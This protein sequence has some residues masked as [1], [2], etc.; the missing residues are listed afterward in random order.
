MN[1][2]EVIKEN[3]KRN[4]ELDSYYNPITGE[5]SLIPKIKIYISNGSYISMP[6]HVQHFDYFK[7][8]V[9]KDEHFH[10]YHVI[11]E[12]CI[13][14]DDVISDLVR[15][16]LKEDFEF[17]AAICLTIKHKELNI[18]T[19][20]IFNYAQRILHAA[21]EKQRMS[22]LPERI[23]TCKARQWGS[24]TY[25]ILRTFWLQWRTK[26][27]NACIVSTV[28]NQARGVRAKYRKS[29]NRFPKQLG[30]IKLG[31]FEGSDKNIY[32]NAFES[33]ISIGSME[34]PESLRSEDNQIAL[35]TEV[36]S[37]KE[38]P[39]R[40][41]MDLVQNIKASVLYKP[42][43]MIVEES[44]AKGTGNYW[45]NSWLA[46]KNNSKDRY[47]GVFIAWFQ[48]EM[49]RLPIK[50]EEYSGFINSLSDDEKIMWAKGA[51]LEGLKW[52]R[53]HLEFEMLGNI[54]AMRSEYPSD[55]LEAFQSTGHKR[56][57][58]THIEEMSA[59]CKPPLAKGQVFGEGLKGKSALKDLV[60][61]PTA[62]GDLWLWAYPDKKLL[63]KNRYVVSVDI[64]GTH[65]KSDYSVMRIFD[66]LPMMYGGGPDCIGTYRGHIDQ[67]TFAWYC[68]MVSTYFNNALLII[69]FNSL[70]KEKETEGEHFLTILDE[71]KDY[72]NNI[73]ARYI[74]EDVRDKI[75]TKYGFHTNSATKTMIIDLYHALLRDIGYIEYDQ[76]AMNECSMFEVKENGTLGAVKGHHD[77][78]VIATSIGLWACTSY[79]PPPKEY[80]KVNKNIGTKMVSESIM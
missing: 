11:Y 29:A 74:P 9:R 1:V 23:K 40:T 27:I 67:D 26:G 32:N 66:R 16:R 25:E 19:A 4:E 14:E 51:T 45:H 71:I 36:G 2:R 52:Y 69:E 50:S 49:Y 78:I 6:E 53:N 79:L 72:Y 31:R 15:I 44:T 58:P 39:S 30:E 38:T 24:T 59:L 61:T 12:R 21:H 13:K 7:K 54:W 5:G 42:D 55:D 43:T 28:E 62:N 3:R 80:T 60:F 37:W 22:G 56:F 46:T 34:K 73:Y 57:N 33:I 18:D 77:D 47:I 70:D 63:I 75:P 64:G 35:C 48:I 41:P 8:H 10:K 68:A 76:R 17:F 65:Y 20:F